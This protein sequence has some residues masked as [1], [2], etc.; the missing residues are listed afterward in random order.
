MRNLKRTISFLLAMTLLCALPQIAHA[1]DEGLTASNVSD[2]P[3]ISLGGGF[4]PLFFDENTP[5]QTSA[6]DPGIAGD[7]FGAVADDALAAVKALKFDLAIDLLVET[8]RR[9]FGPIGMDNNG[10]S[11]AKNISCVHNNYQAWDLTG[12]QAIYFEFDWRLD[13]VENAQRLNEYIEDYLVPLRGVEK[14]NLWATS[15]SSSILL[16]YLKLFDPELEHVASIVLYVPMLNGNTMFGELVKRKLVLDPEALAKTD[17]DSLFGDSLGDFALNPLLGV[18]YETGLLGVIERLAKLAA[19]S[20]VDRVYAEVLPLVLTMP[21]FWS[22]VPYKDYE[23]GIRAMFC[24]KPEYGG[25]VAKLNNYHYNVM[26]YADEVILHASQHVKVAVFAGYGLP[27]YP[28]GAGTAVQ[29]DTIVDTAY[30]SL[31]ATCAPLGTPFPSCYAQKKYADTGKNYISP[32][33]LIDAST[34][35]LPDSTW[36]VLNRPHVSLQLSESWYEWFK[37]ATVKP[38]VFAN[39][40]YPQYFERISVGED[41]FDIPLVMELQPIPRWLEVLKIAGLW[42][43][44][45]WRWLLLLPMFW[46]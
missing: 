9:W 16:A 34:C 28:L 26:Q 15:G 43:L 21:S 46:V 19:K 24:G 4:H 5:E 23:A 1:Q 32:D 29:S 25:L 17:W 36:F 14:Y 41:L 31:G 33:R 20:V 30:A 13:P 18:L 7:V 3:T 2:Y 12:N 42:L 35:L 10:D 8:C 11:I 27:L 37:S 22:Y 6:F 44:K 45:I 38:T 39:E 40:N